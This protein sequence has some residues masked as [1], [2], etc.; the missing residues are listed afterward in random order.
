MNTSTPRQKVG[1]LDEEVNKF[2]IALAISMVGIAFAVLAAGG[3]AGSWDEQLIKFFR[4]VLL[5]CSII[6]ISMRINLDFAKIW[7]SYCIQNDEKIPGAI[8]RTSQIPE[9]LGRIQYLL[10][11][12]TGTLTKNEMIFKKIEMEHAQYSEENV[13]EIC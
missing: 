12:K 4:I 5:L 8:A 10:S 11:D 1:L 3:F 6:P 2:T 9:E 13:N 7:Y